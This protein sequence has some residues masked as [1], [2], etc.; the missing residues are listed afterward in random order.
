M[1]KEKRYQDAG[2]AFLEKQ[3]SAFNGKFFKI[4]DEEK[5]NQYK[6]ILLEKNV[7]PVIGGQKGNADYEYLK[8]QHNIIGLREKIYEFNEEQL[9]AF[10]EK[11]KSTISI[12]EAVEVIFQ[13]FVKKFNSTTNEAQQYQLIFTHNEQ[14][15]DKNKRE[16]TFEGIK[17][18]FFYNVIYYETPGQYKGKNSFYTIREKRIP[19]FKHSVKTQERPDFVHYINGIPLILI[20]YKTED[21]GILKALKDFE[22][23]ESYKCIPFKIA[24][25]DGKDVLFF[26]NVELL[27]GIQKKDTSF[28]WVHYL[29]EKKFVGQREYLN[30]EYLFEEL[31]CQPKNMYSYCVDSCTLVNSEDYHY[32]INARIQQYYAI[33]DITRTLV[34]TSTGLMGLP[35]NFEFAHAQR[36]GKTITMK[37]ITYLIEQSF[38]KLFNTVFMYAPDLQIKDVINNEFSRSGNER[39]N[40][41]IVE[42]RTEYQNIINE[43]YQAEQAGIEHSGMKVFV[44][45]MQKIS[46]DEFKKTDTRKVL[47]SRKILNIID[48]AHHG[49]TKETASIREQIFSNASN[50]LFTATGKSDMYLYYFPDNNREGF[51]NKFTISHA[52]KCEIT[53]PVLFMQ[54]QKKF[55][56]GNAIEDFSKM[57]EN[58]LSERYIKQKQAMGHNPEKE[59]IEEYLDGAS[60]EVTD[61]IKQEIRENSFQKKT[62]FLVHQFKE[63]STGIDAFKPKFIIYC[64]SV[65]EAKKYIEI[66]QQSGENK[67]EKNF[68]KGYRFGTDFSSI[69]DVCEK[70]NPGIKE[71]DDISTNFEKLRSDTDTENDSDLIIDAL[72]AVDKYQKGFDLPALLATFLDTN[73][74]EPARLNQIYT[75]SATKATGK[76]IGYCV[77]MAFESQNDLTY[78]QS[79]L[80]YDNEDIEGGFIDE[81]LLNSLKEILDIEFQKLKRNLD[82]DDEN[83]TSNM[84]LQQLLNEVDLKLREKRQSIFFNSSRNIIKN[85]TK[86]GSP[87]LFKPFKNELKALYDSFDEFKKIY[88]DKGHPENHKILIGLDDSLTEKDVYITENEIRVVIDEVL[89]FLQQHNI[90]NLISLDYETSLK[91]IKIDNETSK[92]ISARFAQELN[93]NSLE[94][95]FGDLNDFIKRNH[96]ELFDLIR[97][98]LTRISDDRSII[99]D[100]L[101]QNEIT[102]L[103]NKISVVK[104][105]IQNEIKQNYNGDAMLYWIEQGLKI[106]LLE[107]NIEGDKFCRFAAEEINASI[108]SILEE[109]PKNLPLHEK[110]DAIIILLKEKFKI[111]SIGSMTLGFYKSKIPT[112]NEFKELM[113][114]LKNSPLYKGQTTISSEQLFCD[115]LTQ[116]LNNYNKN[117]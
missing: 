19:I 71:S 18:P 62:D 21:S 9:K 117:T 80:L 69:Q 3:F 60:K 96:R 17:S 70:Y 67:C 110:T 57:V 114:N 37:L 8:S 104:N 24:L 99:Y 115:I 111:V 112:P 34:N 58:V 116:S 29:S 100:D 51:S 6:D 109:M 78:K 75:R 106:K 42:S 72:F 83:F 20:E 102:Q 25:N 98:M 61:T 79:I 35:Y 52:K 44:V 2:Q 92:E 36:S 16:V 26:S 93:K 38:G 39:V 10:L 47:K 97:D 82:L 65:R 77:D 31:L 12:T 66:I 108:K 4:F 86:V 63:L 103:Q 1:S 91:E 45:N 56:L 87:L 7:T 101:V 33:K 32:L 95:S 15:K 49:Q 5:N 43:L 41:T 55:Q 113:D 14:I 54:A 73:I 84:I 76:T 11:H 68:Y 46:E 89:H 50:Y 13:D 74:A 90:K 81:A 22:F 59:E 88:A 48:E 64:N 28:R 85:M 40:L 105:K 27:S 107:Q 53:V 23:K 30:I 94:A